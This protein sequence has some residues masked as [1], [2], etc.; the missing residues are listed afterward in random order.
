MREG[1]APTASLQG[2]AAAEQPLLA[3]IVWTPGMRRM[4]SLL[5]RCALISQD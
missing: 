1:D 3:G 4:Y 2:A 5:D